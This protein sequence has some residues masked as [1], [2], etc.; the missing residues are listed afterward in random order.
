MKMKLVQSEEVRFS[1]FSS[2]WTGMND[3]SKLVFEHIGMNNK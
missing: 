1:G 2:T 3:P